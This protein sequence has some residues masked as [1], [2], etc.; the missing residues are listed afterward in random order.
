MS[1]SRFWERTMKR[2]QATH[3]GKDGWQ[4]YEMSE[5]LQSEISLG[6]L[7]DFLRDKHPGSLVRRDSINEVLT[8]DMLGEDEDAHR[9]ASGTEWDFMNLDTF[10]WQGEVDVAWKDQPI[11]YLAVDVRA[12]QGAFVR[13]ALAATKSNHALREFH[14]ELRKYARAREKTEGRWIRVIN[15]NRIPVPDASWE[16]LILPPGLA[17]E[18]REN[19][20]AFFSEK[21]A[22]IYKKLGVS[23]R[24]GYIFAGPPG[25][26]K[27]QTIRSIANST[28][29]S[30][31]ALH[32]TA[33]LMDKVL[34]HA[35]ELANS[36]AP[37]IL[38][39][40]DLDRVTEC[41]DVGVSHLLNLLDGLK[42][43]EGLL[44]IATSNHPEKLD[45]ALLHRPSRFDRVWT[46]PLPAIA[47]RRSL[48][49]RKGSRFFSSE[50]LDEAARLS[51]GFSMAYTQE[52]VVNA[53]LLSAKQGGVPLDH[54]LISSARTLRKQLKTARKAEES[55]LEADGIGFIGAQDPIPTNH[56]HN[57]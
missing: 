33:D 47:E 14:N 57:E 40:E 17:D 37:A 13:C 24:R 25:C 10:D 48:L 42:E 53:L 51:D 27:T 31:F 16:D 49:G 21:T 22:S 39:L 15:G 2:F 4:V 46:F 11:H 36:L 5:R 20:E 1:E 50:G 41:R 35:F 26:G 19:I 43:S 29:A 56:N 6:F 12:N 18:I 55:R 45:P 7:L 9:M 52:I 34:S 23:Y 44:V 32:V 28:K 54:H 38:I 8:E 30:L 3:P